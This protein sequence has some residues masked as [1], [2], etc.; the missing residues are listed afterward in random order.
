MK[1]YACAHVIKCESIKNPK[2]HKNPLPIFFQLHRVNIAERKYSL[3]AT[4]DF[5]SLYVRRAE[6]R[7]KKRERERERERER[8]GEGKRITSKPATPHIRKG[9]ST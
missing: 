6:R 2:E 3:D 5:K 4:K 8:K 7:K 1:C 9:N